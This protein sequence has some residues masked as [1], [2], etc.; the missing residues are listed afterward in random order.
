MC[1]IFPVARLIG[2]SGFGDSFGCVEDAASDNTQE[3][4]FLGG[5]LVWNDAAVCGGRMELNILKRY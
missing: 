1:T 5:G 2:R 3:I 4:I